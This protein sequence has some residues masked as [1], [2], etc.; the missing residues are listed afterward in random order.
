MVAVVEQEDT[1][2]ALRHQEG[3]QRGVGLGRVAG[4]AGQHQVVRTVVGRLA[5]TGP[6]VVE[7]DG[8][9]WNAG[10]AVRADRAVMREQ[11]FAMGAVGA[12]GRLAKAGAC[13]AVG[14]FRLFSRWCD[15]GTAATSRSCHENPFEVRF[16]NRVTLTGP[17]RFREGEGGVSDP[18]PASTPARTAP[19]APARAQFP[20]AWAAAPL[21]R[22]LRGTRKSESPAGSGRHPGR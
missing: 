10:T 11:P 4:T 8:F 22:R 19:Q 17:D 20:V 2:S 13:A 5:T 9:R 21:A 18:A 16:W 7:R 15:V 14:S 1:A 3:E 12:S 6:D